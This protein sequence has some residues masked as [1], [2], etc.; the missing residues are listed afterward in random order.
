MR[1]ALECTGAGT[2]AKS[3]GAAIGALE[4]LGGV[5]HT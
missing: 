5:R 4:S 2:L 1:I 3:D